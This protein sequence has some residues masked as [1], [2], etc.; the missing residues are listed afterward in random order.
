M[1]RRLLALG[2]SAAVMGVALAP[3]PE[4]APQAEVA[5]PGAA[6]AVFLAGVPVCGFATP[7]ADESVPDRCDNLLPPFT[8]L[9]TPFGLG[10]AAFRTVSAL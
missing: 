2:I 8:P 10:S 9:P 4:G 7:P 3:Q 5:P 6:V 1:K